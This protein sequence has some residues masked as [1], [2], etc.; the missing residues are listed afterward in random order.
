MGRVTFCPVAAKDG[1]VQ[2]KVTPFVPTFAVNAS[3]SPTQSVSGNWTI[4]A[5]I[6]HCA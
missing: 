2:A 4:D 6:V 1:P 5:F 3:V